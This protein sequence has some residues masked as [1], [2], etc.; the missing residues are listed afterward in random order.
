MDILLATAYEILEGERCSQCGLY[1]W[2][3]HSEDPGM[4]FEVLED[5]CEATRAVANRSKQ[6]GTAKKLEEKPWIKLRPNPVMADQ[7]RDFT[8]LRTPYFEE[9]SRRMGIDPDS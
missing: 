7:E 5:S 2:I 3:C 1:V 8:D 4:Q 6:T 9:E